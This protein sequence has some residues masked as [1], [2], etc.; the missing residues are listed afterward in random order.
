[1]HHQYLGKLQPATL[2][3]LPQAARRPSCRASRAAFPLRGETLGAAIKLL[4]ALAAL[5]TSGI[6][7]LCGAEPVGPT[8]PNVLILFLDDVG[9]GDLACY[10]ATDIATPHLDRVAR[11]GIRFSQFYVASPICSASRCGLITGQYPARWRIYSFLQTRAGNRACGQVD[12]LDPSAPLYVRAFQQ[13]GY[14]TAHVGK[15]HLGGGRD[16]TD[17]PPFAAYGYDFGWGTYESP[18]PAAPLGLKTTPWG[19]QLEPQQVPR[20]D[21]TRWMVDQTLSFI[22]QNAQRPWLVN[23]WLDDLHTPFRPSAEQRSRVAAEAPRPVEYRAVL[24]EMD[25]QIGRLLDGL[26]EL[27]QDERTLLIVAGD[28]GPEPTYDRRRTLGLRGMKWSLYEGGIRTPL[29][30]RWKGTVPAGVVN[31]TTV[32]AAIDLFPT[33]LTLAGLPRPDSVRFDG[34]DLSAAFQGQTP[35]RIAPLFWQYG[36]PDDPPPSG[37]VQGFPYPREPLARS[38]VLAVREGDWKL[39]MNPDSSSIELYDLARDPREENN[40]ASR[41]PE[42]AQRLANEL[43]AWHKSLP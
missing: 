8:R 41:H 38:P 36:R 6:P 20:H 21:R 17:A 28:N 35:R 9:L 2:A 26:A 29:L 15:W 40:L 31:D 37:P 39:L 14:A 16:V 18:Q 7:L 24:D 30:V 19:T 42:V 12:Y 32:I 23:L 1:M 10:G 43:R 13:A 27:G 34:E 11:E 33:L 3:W 5:V 4:L 25:R 22:R